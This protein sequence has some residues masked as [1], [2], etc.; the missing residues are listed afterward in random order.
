MSSAIAKL[1][2]AINQMIGGER[3]IKRRVRKIGHEPTPQKKKRVNHINPTN[4]RR[5]LIERKEK[6]RRKVAAKQR[7]INRLRGVG[8]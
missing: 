1:L 2:L 3:P 4:D 5:T 8:I 6:K 7:Q